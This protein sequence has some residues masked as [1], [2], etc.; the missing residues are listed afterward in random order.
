M[1]LKKT[2]MINNNTP[3]EIDTINKSLKSTL[4]SLFFISS[5]SYMAALPCF[6]FSRIKVPVSIQADNLLSLIS[7][8]KDYC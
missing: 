8:V 1:N 3:T 4:S 2:Y 7:I 5:P 6:L